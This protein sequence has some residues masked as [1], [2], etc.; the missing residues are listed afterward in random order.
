MSCRP[1]YRSLFTFG[2]SCT[3]LKLLSA[4]MYHKQK[5]WHYIPYKPPRTDRTIERCS[6]T[7]ESFYCL[8]SQGGLEGWNLM[9][10]KQKPV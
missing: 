10:T 2:F 7:I 3:T 9:P 5:G 1:T 8:V 4:C 6:N